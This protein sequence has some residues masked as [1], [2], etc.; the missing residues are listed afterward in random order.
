MQIVPDIM[1]QR[2]L[3]FQVDPFTHLFLENGIVYSIYF[4]NNT[5]TKEIDFDNDDYMHDYQYI[6]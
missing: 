2:K 6:V 1:T 5:L 4:N 3:F